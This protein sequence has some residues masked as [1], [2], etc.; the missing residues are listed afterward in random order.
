MPEFFFYRHDI[1]NVNINQ[2]LKR[3][4]DWLHTYLCTIEQ[5]GGHHFVV[6]CFYSVER[7]KNYAA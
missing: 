3:R 5:T 1:G 4:N 7:G 6:K 2:Y